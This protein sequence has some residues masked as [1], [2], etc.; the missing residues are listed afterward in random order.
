MFFLKAL[1]EKS[2]DALSLYNIAIIY[3]KKADFE[4]ADFYA[5]KG[6]KLYQTI[7]YLTIGCNL[8]SCCLLA[9][10]LRLVRKVSAQV[11]VGA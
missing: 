5:A 6:K 7:G 11:K 4:K 1:E 9:L 3:Y 10:V 2:D 8:F